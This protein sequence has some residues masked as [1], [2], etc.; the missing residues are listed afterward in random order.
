MFSVLVSDT[1]HVWKTEAGRGSRVGIA[2]VE[3]EGVAL[4]SADGIAEGLA[5]S[6]GGGGWYFGA[7][8][9]VARDG[10]TVAPAVAAPA[11]RAAIVKPVRTRPFTVVS[12]VPTRRDYIAG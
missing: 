12:P 5:A 6:T 8:E 9:G 11:T 4:G 3:G 7:A 1:A 2:E 10:T